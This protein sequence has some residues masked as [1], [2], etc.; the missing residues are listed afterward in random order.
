MSLARDLAVAL[1][2]SHSYF[3]DG[4]NLAPYIGFEAIQKIRCLRVV[5]LHLVWSLC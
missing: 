2:L 4:S 1:G 5:V 3:P